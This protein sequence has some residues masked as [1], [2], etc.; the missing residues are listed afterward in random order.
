MGMVPEAVVAMLACA[1]IGATHNVVFG[2]FSG[3]ALRD[4]LND[5]H[6]KIL[7]TTAHTAE[8]QRLH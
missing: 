1:K 6:A 8:A 3:E 4:R 2:G 7:I 5:S